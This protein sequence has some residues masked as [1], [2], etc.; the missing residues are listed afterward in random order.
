MMTF[1]HVLVGVIAGLSAGLILGM[2]YLGG[3]DCECCECCDSCECGQ[4]KPPVRGRSEHGW[5]ER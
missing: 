3:C 1:I 4:L 5:M 2:A